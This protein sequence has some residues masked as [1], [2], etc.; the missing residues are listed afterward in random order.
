MWDTAWKS[1]KH[2]KP[3][4]EEGADGPAPACPLVNGN[5]EAGKAPGVPPCLFVLGLLLS[6]HQ[7]MARRLTP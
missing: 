3:F 1:W 7:I 4:E 5:H 6:L 2:E